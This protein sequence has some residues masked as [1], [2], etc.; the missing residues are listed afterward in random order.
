MTAGNL[1]ILDCPLAPVC[2]KCFIHCLTTQLFINAVRL[3]FEC[4][5]NETADDYIYALLNA[6]LLLTHDPLDPLFIS[7]QLQQVIA[8]SIPSLMVS[9]ICHFFGTIALVRDI[10]VYRLEKLQYPFPFSIYIVPLHPW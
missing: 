2:G 6:T 9:C 5:M 3:L 7:K 1:E 8:Q 10:F 4:T